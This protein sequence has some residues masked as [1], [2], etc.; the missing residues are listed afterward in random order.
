MAYIVVTD[1]II[2]LLKNRRINMPLKTGAKLT[3]SEDTAIETYCGFFKGTTLPRRAG[4]FSYSNSGLHRL[5][6][7]GRYCS[8]AAGVG[9]MG[10]GHPHSWVSISPFSYNSWRAHANIV[11]AIIDAE[12]A[13]SWPSLPFQTSEGAPLIGNDVWIGQD[14]LLSQGITIGDGAVI[15]ARA[16]VTRDVAPYTIVG[17]CPAKILRRRFPEELSERL[18]ASQWW[19]YRFTDFTG[20]A[21]D[22]PHV[23]LDQLEEKV[24]S[25]GIRPYRPQ[26]LTGDEL[27]RAAEV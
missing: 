14:V 26:A 15:A 17:G 4:A 23:F 22:K 11:D 1:A 6:S 20:M 18:L 5:A 9:V 3:F 16:V 25:G 13:D 7:M 19:D 21:F 27:R 10:N 2:Q 12:Q 24:A 8:I